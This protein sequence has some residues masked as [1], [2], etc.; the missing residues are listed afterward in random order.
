MK[1]IAIIGAGPGLGLSLAK[2]FGEKGF[3][4]AVISRNPKKLAIIVNELK[5]LNIEAK[6]YVADVRDLSAL[7]QAL[8]AVKQDFG[9]IDVL[10]FSPYAGP[11]HFKHVLET[12]AEDVLEQVKG[13]LLPAVLSVNEVIPD[14]I[15]NAS[16]AILLT[17]GIS[18]MVS[19]PS[20]GNV[21]MVMSGVRNYATNLHFELK[22]KG[23][24]VGHL[25]I[26]TV[27]QAGTAGDPDL[28]AE[29]WYNL[30]EKKDCFEDTFPQEINPT[31]L[32]N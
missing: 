17:T 15:N 25:S 23:I 26:G 7:K 9:H 10:E 13:Y 24:Y 29:A 6:S 27:I 12:T 22:E 11:T 19:Y 14:M 2:K 31:K 18:A 28:I 5:K 32:S 16:G 3:R 30:Y 1:T 21:G 20:V 8:D 4:V